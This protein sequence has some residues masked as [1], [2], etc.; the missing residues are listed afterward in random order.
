[1]LGY[2]VGE[3]EVETTLYPFPADRRS[4]AGLM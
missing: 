3:V 1:M 2:F 4:L